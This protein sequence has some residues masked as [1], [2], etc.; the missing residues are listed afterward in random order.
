MFQYVHFIVPFNPNIICYQ[1]LASA[2]AVLYVGAIVSSVVHGIFLAASLDYPLD[3]LPGVKSFLL[4]Q[5]FK[6]FTSPSSEEGILA[7]IREW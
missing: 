3:V 5:C 6:L 7:H 2:L 1:W 4:G